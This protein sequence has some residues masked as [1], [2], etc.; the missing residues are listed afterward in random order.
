MLTAPPFLLAADETQTDLV[1]TPKVPPHTEMPPEATAHTRFY[2]CR[3]TTRNFCAEESISNT[4]YLMRDINMSVARMSQVNHDWV[5]FGPAVHSDVHGFGA[6]H[7]FDE[8][9]T[10]NDRSLQL[11]SLTGL[12]HTYIYQRTP[13]KRRCD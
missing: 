11:I 13:A 7:T 9:K 2:A 6:W 8:R 5:G 4:V 3:W 1:S 12:Y 10:S